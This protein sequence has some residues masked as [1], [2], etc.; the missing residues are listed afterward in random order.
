MRKMTIAVLAVSCSCVAIL[1]QGDPQPTCKMCPGTY[2][3]NS[4]IQA[5][6]AKA[7]AEIK[8]MLVE[9]QV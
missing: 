3:P 2:I 1:A 6:A 5:Y 9:R 7:I 8:K 4:E